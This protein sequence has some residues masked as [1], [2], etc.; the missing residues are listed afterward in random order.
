MPETAQA[1]NVDTPVKAYTIMQRRWAPIDA[2]CSGTQGMRDLALTGE[3]KY[4]VP[5]PK[6]DPAA[7]RRRVER[8]V[9]FEAFK[10]TVTSMVS[11]P[12]SRDISFREIEQAGKVLESIRKNADLAGTSLHGVL[13]ACF[14]ASLKYGISHLLVDN[15]AVP[16][17]LTVAEENE[18]GLR[19]SIVH[20]R[21]DQL[22][23]WIVDRDLAGHPF[24]SQ[25]RIREKFCQPVPPW[26]EKEVE[27]IR[28]FNAPKGGE[29][30]T[31]QIHRRSD[32][33][34]WLQHAS[35]T[36]DG[37]RIPL[38]THYTGRTGLMT[39]EPPLEALAWAN[40]E[41]W[42]SRSDQAN[43]VRFARI[44]MLYLIGFTEEEVKKFIAGGVSWGSIPWSKN[45]SAKVGAVEH[46]GSAI[47]AG[48]RDVKNIEQRMEVLGLRPFLER[49]D[50]TTATGVAANESTQGSILQGWV[51]GLAIVAT[52]AVRYA[53]S[54][55]NEEVPDKFAVQIHRDFIVPI[56]GRE[57]AALLLQAFQAMAIDARTLVTELKRRG[58]LGENVD[59]DEV[60]AELQTNPPLAIKSLASMVR[61]AGAGTGGSGTNEGAA[62][63]AA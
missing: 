15:P 24:L 19:P 36:Y 32:D 39:A 47:E 53:L 25:I 41:H 3:G 44:A 8:S 63:A 46:Q 59:V 45:E 34:K 55:A 58:I 12:F 52:E 61:G 16:K 17:G 27:Q 42:Q 7:F 13:E 40:I 33:G 37:T 35:G 18:L 10:D 21:P 26:G 29:P 9:L 51:S 4:L 48:E 57:D 20:V 43:C 56:A 60:L 1:A 23:G 11:K 22:I 2:V 49:R 30:G 50:T 14:T 54:L 62:G 38:F 6:E 5:E 28:V 31:W